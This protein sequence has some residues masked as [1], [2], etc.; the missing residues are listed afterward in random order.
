MIVVGVIIKIRVKPVGKLV[1][2][3]ANKS[4]DPDEP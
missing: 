2:M 1:N 3:N 4:Y